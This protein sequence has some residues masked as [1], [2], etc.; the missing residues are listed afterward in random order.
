[1]APK[2]AELFLCSV[3]LLTVCQYAQS[4]YTDIPPDNPDYVSGEQTLYV[5]YINRRTN[6]EQ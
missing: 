6:L 2:R 1:M 4:Y 5:S 3:I